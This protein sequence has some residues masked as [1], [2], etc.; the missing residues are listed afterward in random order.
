VNLYEK[1]VKLIPGGVN[2]P[3]RAFKAVGGEPLFIKRGIGGKIYDITGK[4]YVDYVMSYGPLILGHADKN[5]IKT[6]IETAKNGTTFG[7][8]LN[9]KLRLQK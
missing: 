5:V 7:A 8:P 2:S 9:L 3:V 4:E 1:A 6:I